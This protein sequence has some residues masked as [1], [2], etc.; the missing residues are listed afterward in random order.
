MGKNYRITPEGTRDLI[1]EECVFRRQ[2]EERMEQLFGSRG[3]AEVVTPEIEFLDVFTQAYNVISEESM[4]KLS[5][6]KGR[7]IALRP[8]ST[9]PIARLVSTRLRDQVLPL[10]LFYNQ[11][12]YHAAPSLTGRND[13]EFQSGIEMIGVSGKRADLEVLFTAVEALECCNPSNYRLEIGHIA[14]FN[15]LMEKLGI[16]EE[17]KEEIRLLIESKNYP[18]LN[19]LVDSRL[20]PKD[21]AQMKQLPRLFGGDEIF[22]KAITLFEDAE[23]TKTVEYLRSL[24][25]ALQ[26][27]GLGEKIS[28]DLGIVNQINY[29]TGVIFR[30]YISG[31]GRAILSGGRYDHL[32]AAFGMPSPAVGF[33]INLDAVLASLL[34]NTPAH[35]LS[36][37][38]L[39]VFSPDGFEVE[40]LLYSNQ[41]IQQGKNVEYCVFDSLDRAVE[42]ANRKGIPEIAVVGDT[43]KMIRPEKGGDR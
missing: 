37:A 7:L 25:T 34:E 21:A 3:F 32:F 26:S 29:Y 17:L 1:F 39:L 33:G 38:E 2:L 6:R 12:V 23:I 13:E 11:K 28:V 36:N 9:M 40:G 22:D 10:R 43:I 30:G 42:Y 18:A 4:Y 15:R 27:Y 5:D 8:D 35:P 14:I 19:D 41:Q 20:T 31:F 16:G 24:Y